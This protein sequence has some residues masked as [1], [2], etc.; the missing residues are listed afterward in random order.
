MKKT[1]I[2]INNYLLGKLTIDDVYKLFCKKIQE[3]VENDFN[4]KTTKRFRNRSRKISQ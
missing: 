1:K 3:E 2:N 4:R